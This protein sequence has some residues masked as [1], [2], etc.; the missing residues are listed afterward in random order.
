MTR[1]DVALRFGVSPQTVTRWANAEI[2]PYVLTLGGQRRYPAYEVE[3][4]LGLVWEH[5][6]PGST[7][8]FLQHLT[9][10]LVGGVKE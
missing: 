8:V 7:P 2:L 3:R 10:T 9:Q 1:R 6:L 4:L 5:G